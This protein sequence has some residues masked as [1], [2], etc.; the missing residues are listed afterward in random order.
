MALIPTWRS[1]CGPIGS[2]ATGQSTDWSVC[3]SVS[4]LAIARRSARGRPL[5]S[6]T[7][8]CVFSFPSVCLSVRLSVSLVFRR[9]VC[10]C[11]CRSVCLS[12]FR[13][14]C[15]SACLF[16]GL[17]IGRLGCLFVGPACLL[18]FG[19]VWPLACPANVRLLVSWC[20]GPSAFVFLS[21]GL[22]FIGS[23]LLT[24]CGRAICMVVG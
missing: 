9:L 11:G 1:V 15:R 13:A 14:V 20:A 6:R 5:S 23:N 21:I 10:P 4:R 18:D 16:F 2:S 3:P 12:V 17:S 24:V 7:V 19:V 8:C 22:F